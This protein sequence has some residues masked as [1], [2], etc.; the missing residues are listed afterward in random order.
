[1]SDTLGPPETVSDSQNT[2]R[3]ASSATEPRPT[4]S[5]KPASIAVGIAVLLILIGLT[6][7]LFRYARDRFYPQ[8]WVAFYV[9]VAL[10]TGLSFWL[11]TA[12]ATGEYTNSRL[13][14]RLGGGAGIG[15]C[16]MVLAR[17]LTPSPPLLGERVIKIQ[18]NAAG[19]IFPATPAPAW[20]KEIREVLILDENGSRALVL[21]EDGQME[22]DIFLQYYKS[23]N[24]F[25]HCSIHVHQIG[26]PEQPKET[27]VADSP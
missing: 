23:D 11:L 24:R 15:A 10:I 9:S 16:F 1:M 7:V 20:S 5:T 13:G 27:P 17:V 4:S 26:D 6:V 2:D 21:F 22:G 19:H 25:Y 14:L 8:Y 12:G 18:V 3:A